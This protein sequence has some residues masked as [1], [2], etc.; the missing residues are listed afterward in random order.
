MAHEPRVLGAS[1]AEISRDERSSGWSCL[2]GVL[3]HTLRRT[4][5]AMLPLSPCNFCFLLRAS[6]TSCELPSILKLRMAGP[7]NRR[8]GHMNLHGDHIKDHILVA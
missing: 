1:S 3:L 2:S 8:D 5:V 6:K 7:H 4:D